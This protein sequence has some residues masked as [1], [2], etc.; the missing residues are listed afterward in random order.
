MATLKEMQEIIAR[1]EKERSWPSV[2]SKLLA[3]L[4]TTAE[5]DKELLE[6]GYSERAVAHRIAVYLEE[7]FYGWHVDCEFNRQ[8]PADARTSKSVS[9]KLPE[10]PPTGERDG[11]IVTPDIV[12]HR[13]RTDNNL[14]V[15][16]VKPSDSDGLAR[17]REK[18][19]KFVTDAHLRY[20]YAA[21]VTYRV[22]KNA[23]FEPIESF[24]LAPPAAD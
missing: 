12:I 6:D 18:L 2:E 3:A 7:A 10:L 20:R 13:R 1:E 21:L 24:H 15:I 4:K 17:D 11:A 23:G 19:L 8:G 14:L 5:R 16:E 22:G 9:S